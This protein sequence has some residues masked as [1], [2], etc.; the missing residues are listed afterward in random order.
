[1]ERKDITRIVTEEQ[2]ESLAFFEELRKELN[3]LSTSQIVYVVEK[4][5]SCVRRSLSLQQTKTFV[6]KL[7]SLFQLLFISNWKTEEEKKSFA[8][9]D[10]LVIC[11]FEEDQTS[12]KSVF[13]SEV[14]ALQATIIVFHKLN[15]ALNLFEN[16]Y[17]PYSL[18]E[19]IRQVP[20]ENAA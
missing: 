9:L 8:H 18:V 11:L 6:S 5:L 16:N 19:E 7:P 1:M 10:E 3:T 4:V 15:K 14:E 17:L 13:K 2:L 12:G 20:L